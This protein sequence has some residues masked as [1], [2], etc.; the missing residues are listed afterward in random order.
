MFLHDQ[1]AMIA[2]TTM[3]LIKDFYSNIFHFIDASVITK[4]LITRKS[5]SVWPLP[6][7]VN[8]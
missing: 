6:F 4:H 2:Q 7:W 8:E 3:G 1:V 5:D